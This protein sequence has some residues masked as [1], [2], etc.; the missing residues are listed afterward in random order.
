MKLGTIY[1]YTI[2]ITDWIPLLQTDKF[3][4]IL[5]DRLEYLVK[6]KKLIVYSL[7]IMPNHIHVIW[8]NIAMNGRELPSASFMKFKGHSFLE[9]LQLANNPILQRF[10]V[11][12]YDRK[13]QFW[14]RSGL[15]V[16]MY[17]KKI[18]EQKLDYIHFNPLQEHWKL[19]I[20]PSDYYF[21]T[22][23]FYERGEKRFDWVTH[24]MDAFGG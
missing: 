13:H 11:E 20:D 9:E 21:S 24:Y 23:S 1:F 12:R 3:K 22:C 14:Q 4:Q 18:L 5:L 8:E 16:F 2:A 7:V 6:E 19:V 17:N 15:S 10:K